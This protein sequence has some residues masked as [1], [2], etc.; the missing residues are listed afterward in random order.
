MCGYELFDEDNLSRMAYDWIYR[1]RP[2]GTLMIDGDDNTNTVTRGAYASVGKDAL[3]LAFV[4]SKDPIIKREFLYNGG[5]IEQYSRESV[6]PIE[7]M[8]LNDPYVKADVATATLP[9]TLYNP[10]PVGEM[11]AR[12]GWDL[13]VKSP[14]VIK[15]FST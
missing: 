8:L 13:G 10:S 7:K 1:R 3:F 2:D 11:I 6:Q 9:L 4:V 5:F 15:F 14:D 12:T